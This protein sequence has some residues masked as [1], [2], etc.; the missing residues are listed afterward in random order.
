MSI[1]PATRAA[2][3]GATLPI[4][5]GLV[6]LARDALRYG[7]V[8]VVALAVDWGALV[9][10][11]RVFGLHYMAAAA[12]AFSAGLVVAYV[13]TV[14]F[15]FGDRRR[16]GAGAEF[17]GFLATGLVGL[18]LNAAAIYVFVEYVRVPVEFAKAPTA[19]FVFA[20]NFLSRRFLLFSGRRA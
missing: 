11:V 6:A 7:M 20:F 5:P 19:A 1:A 4:R 13:L 17:A 8:S 2:P 12:L 9:L 10:F 16:Y 15:V 18:A 14:A 3:A